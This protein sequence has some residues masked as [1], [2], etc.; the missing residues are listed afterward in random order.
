LVVA[1]ELIVGLQVMWLY[2]DGLELGMTAEVDCY[3]CRRVEFPLA[4]T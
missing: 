1:G 4:F 2:I 3:G